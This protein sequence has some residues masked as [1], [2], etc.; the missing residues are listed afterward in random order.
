M[1]QAA[2]VQRYHRLEGLSQICSLGESLGPT[3]RLFP[4]ASVLTLCPSPPKLARPPAAWNPSRPSKSTNHTNHWQAQ[5]TS[6]RR[7]PLA[8]GIVV[9]SPFHRVLSNG[10]DGFGRFWQQNP[11]S[12]SVLS[13]VHGLQAPC[14]LLLL[15]T[16]P[17]RQNCKPMHQLRSP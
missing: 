9:C 13:R 5:S 1:F 4:T 16:P 10:E 7:T 11:V 8:A 17:R 6:C 14:L 12:E 3:W 2:P 15:S